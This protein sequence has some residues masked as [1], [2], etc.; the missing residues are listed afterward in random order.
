MTCGIEGCLR[1]YT[2]YASWSKH[3]Q[4]KHNIASYTT[5]ELQ[6]ENN[7]DYVEMETDEMVIGEM[8]SDMTEPQSQQQNNRE[9][10][11]WIMKLRDENKLTQSCTENIL[12]NVTLL[13]S[14][15]VD[16]IKQT[17][18]KQLQENE[19]PSYVAEKVLQSIDS[20]DNKQPFKGLETKHQQVSF[21]R[22]HLDYVV[23]SYY[24]IDCICVSHG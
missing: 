4:K 10:A 7:D 21:F 20:P 12:S 23:Y 13:C 22:K 15:L 5:T 19:V 6:M 8:E 11:K 3:V 14:R 17:R 9:T 24:Y 18:A 1:S 2:N 16:N